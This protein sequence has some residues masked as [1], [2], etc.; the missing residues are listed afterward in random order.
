MK[1]LS[2]FFISYPID[3]FWFAHIYEQML[4]FELIYQKINWQVANIGTGYIFISLDKNI[5]ENDFLDI[6]SLPNFC[7][8]NLTKA[9]HIVKEETKKNLDFKPA[10]ELAQFQFN[11]INEIKKITNIIPSIRSIKEF[12]D[13]IV[14]KSEKVLIVKNNIVFSDKQRSVKPI[15]I[16]NV[17]LCLENKNIKQISISTNAQNFLDSYF[18]EIIGRYIAIEIN[19]QNKNKIK[20]LPFQNTNKKLY[21]SYILPKYEK[22]DI[23]Y[24][25]IEKYNKYKFKGPLKIRDNIFSQVFQEFQYFDWG[26]ILS[27]KNIEREIKRKYISYQYQKNSIQLIH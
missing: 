3:L 12:I 13:L 16:K 1:D 23:I 9:W 11:S 2:Y 27:P 17:P 5:N 18:I 6:I 10:Y 20:Y 22:E 8:N 25:I 21:L 19:I 26:L 15:L 4:V 14:E 24:N 7:E